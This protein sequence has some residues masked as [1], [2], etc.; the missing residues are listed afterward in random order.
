MAQESF[1][2]IGTHWDIIINQ[3]LTSAEERGLFLALHER[4]ELFESTYSRFHDGS[5]VDKIAHHA[6][7][8]TLPPDAE[9]MFDLY[10]KLYDITKGAMTPLIGNTLVEAGYDKAYSLIKNTLHTPPQ[11]GDVLVYDFPT[12]KVLSPTQL[13]L[14]AIGKGYL[15]DIVGLMIEEAGIASY[16]INAGGDIRQRSEDGAPLIVGLE[17]PDDKMSVVGTINVMNKSI[18]GSSGNR[19]RWADLHHIIDPHTLR[20]PSDIIA[21][22]AVADTTICADAMTTALFFTNPELLMKEFYFDYL[23]MNADFSVLRSR[24]FTGTLFTS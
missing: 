9:I 13:D 12:L 1:E 5:L 3:K 7:T 4:I 8:Y 6:G 21:V 23:I 24:N 20:S 19:R 18:C 22:W 10:K 2:A 15:I 11:W 14:G 17:H 16:S